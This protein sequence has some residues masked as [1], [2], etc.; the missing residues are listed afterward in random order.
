MAGAVDEGAAAMIAT[1]SLRSFYYAG[2]EMCAYKMRNPRSGPE[3]P[4]SGARVSNSRCEIINAHFRAIVKHKTL[5]FFHRPAIQ[6]IERRSCVRIQARLL[7]GHPR[8]DASHRTQRGNFTGLPG[9]R[10]LKGWCE[11]RDNPDG[12]VSAKAS[13]PRFVSVRGAEGNCDIKDTS[14]L[15]VMHL[16]HYRFLPSGRGELAE[17]GTM[18]K[19][20]ER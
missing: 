20:N 1:I 2:G 15:Y 13:S 3:T 8:G 19:G 17:G 4:I 5:E 10:P 7:S 6:P 16:S 14:G 11:L 18:S 12:L 9:F